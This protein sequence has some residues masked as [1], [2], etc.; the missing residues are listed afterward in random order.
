MYGISDKVDKGNVLVID[1]E[2]LPLEASQ[3]TNW[4]Y[5]RGI[6]STLAASDI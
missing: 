2:A 4:L 3:I 1:S 6:K 5:L